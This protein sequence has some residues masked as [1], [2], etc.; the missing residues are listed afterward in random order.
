MIDNNILFNFFFLI[1]IIIILLKIF[2]KK[3]FG[4]F[5]FL[6]WIGLFIYSL[7]ILINKARKLTYYDEYYLTEINLEYKIIYFCFVEN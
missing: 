4:P 3:I 1:F 5:I 7:P 2:E 6:G